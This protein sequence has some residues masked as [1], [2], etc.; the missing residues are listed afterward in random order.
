MNPR[1]DGIQPDPFDP[2]TPDGVWYRHDLHRYLASKL[3]NREDIHDLAQEAYL[4]YMQSKAQEIREPAA[5]L[6]RIAKN[7]LR[8]WFHLR[9][10]APVL[11]DSELAEARAHHLPDGGADLCEQ[12]IAE[13]RLLRIVEQIPPRYRRVLLMHRRDGLSY[14]EIAARLG[15]TRESVHKYIVRATVF[16]RRAE[17]EEVQG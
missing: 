2:S 14:E 5:Y 10:R 1:R 8:E 4:R 6:F 13:Q 17:G 7:L 9:G 16:A 15:L 12:V 11:C 3:S